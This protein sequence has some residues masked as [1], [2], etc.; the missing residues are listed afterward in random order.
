MTYQFDD[1]NTSQLDTEVTGRHIWTRIVNPGMLTYILHKDFGDSPVSIRRNKRC[2]WDMDDHSLVKKSRKK[3]T[4][5]AK[6]NRECGRNRRRSAKKRTRNL[7]TV[8]LE[9]TSGNEKNIWST[10][11][12]RCG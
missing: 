9:T 10:I 6:I 1:R 3:R 5:S 8:R 7:I 12:N 11:T 4:T 2:P